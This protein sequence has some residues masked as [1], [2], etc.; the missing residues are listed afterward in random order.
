MQCGILRK[1]AKKGERLRK[2]LR[3]RSRSGVFESKGLLALWS[4]HNIFF[5][6]VR[7]FL[8]DGSSRSLICS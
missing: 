3:L 8:K 2:V 1:A 5:V 6:A 4:N 7:T